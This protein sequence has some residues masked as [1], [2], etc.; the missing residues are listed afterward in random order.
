VTASTGF[1]IEIIGE[2]ISPGYR[3]TKAL[4]DA[5][6]VAGLQAL[7]LRQAQAGAACLDVHLG[8]RAARDLPFVARLIGALQAV[9]E[10]PLCFDFPEIPVLETAFAAYD[11]SRARGALPL[12]NSLTDQRWQ[13]MDLY[14]QQPFRVIVMASE[15]VVDGTA[16]SN[17]TAEEIAS[18]AKSM[19]LRL[20]REY[21]IAPGDIYVDVAVRA[22]I[23]DTAGQNRAVLDAIRLIRSEPELAGIH[24]M[25]ALTNIG[26]QM[27]AKAVDGS[28]LKLALEN[29]FLSIAVP[30][31]LDVVMGTPWHDYHPLPEDHHV[32]RV[33]REF[34]GQTGSA[35]LRTIRRFY[36]A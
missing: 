18:T 16:R 29:A 32:L 30:N 14:R 7:A 26:Q 21:G 35:A 6:D 33:Y 1:P 4:I 27:P 25:G 9:V 22:V 28:D 8:T 5:S 34:L 23:V 2:R 36:R 31:G 20:N 10:V 15:R 24:I 13:L 3:S 17:K 19:A 12:L 11:R